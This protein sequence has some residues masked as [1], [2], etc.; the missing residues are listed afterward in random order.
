MKSGKKFATAFNCM[1]GRCQEEVRRFVCSHTDASHVDMVTL[2]GMD[3]ILAGKRPAMPLDSATA[4][5]L[6][7][8]EAGVSAEGHGSKCAFVI[9]HAGCAGNEVS[10]EEHIL[11]IRKAVETVRS[12]ELFESVIGLM[13][14]PNGLG[15]S[16]HSIS[17]N[18]PAA[19]VLEAM[20]A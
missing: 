12:W 6:T 11:D 8:F 10:D 13:A 3:G 14:R 1:D 2:A 17:D 18:A 9:G 19:P 4:I 20:A 5:A 16:L 7:R 15:W